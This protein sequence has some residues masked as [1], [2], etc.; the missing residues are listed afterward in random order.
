MWTDVSTQ[1]VPR[2][3]NLVLSAATRSQL[4]VE[5]GEQDEIG[6][7]ASTDRAMFFRYSGG[8]P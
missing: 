4:K 1:C 5:T 2:S 7:M 3:T 8:L 6:C